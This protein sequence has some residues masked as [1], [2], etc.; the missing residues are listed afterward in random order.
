MSPI[1]YVLIAAAF[2]LVILSIVLCIGA[3]LE[4]PNGWVLRLWRASIWH[5][6]AIPEGEGKV[7]AD[8]K[9]TLLPFYDLVLIGAALLAIRGGMPTFVIVYNDA[10]S[11]SAA[12]SLLGAASLCLIGVAF[13]RLWRLEAAA[14]ITLTTILLVYGVMLLGSSVT[15]PARGFVG[16]LTIAVCLLPV[17]RILWLGDEYRKRKAT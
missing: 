6:D 14:K 17:S 2:S 9:R 11:G 13:P 8:V 3:G 12:W 15:E 4:Q 5:P 1:A 10:V 7:A 16:G